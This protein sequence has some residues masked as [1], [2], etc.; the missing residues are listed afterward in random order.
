MSLLQL[1]QRGSGSAPAWR[2]TWAR[3]WLKPSIFSAQTYIVGLAVLD[4]NGICDFRFITDTDKFGCIYGE[5]GRAHAENLLTTARQCLFRA[6]EMRVPIGRD[7]LPPGFHL[8]PVGYAAGASALDA[9]E[10]ALNEAEIPMEPRPELAKAPR[11]KS[12]TPE[13]VTAAVLDA[14]KNKLGFN[15]NA[16]IREDY[17]GPEAYTARVNLVKSDSA[18]VIASGWYAS[19]ER[20]QLELLRAV[21]VVDSYVA[22]HGKTGQPGVFFLRPTVQSGLRREQNLAIE[23]ALDQIDWQ[24]GQKGLR[25]A[26]R[27]QEVDLADD[28]AEWASA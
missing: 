26:T 24:L 10:G 6:R 15:A 21:T 4:Q 12:R 23:N 11:F 20:V 8:E 19:P 18:G 22:A 25:V 14:L 5:Q 9:L 13:E 1:L 27:D 2:G 16:I 3:I 17:F 7:T 28:I